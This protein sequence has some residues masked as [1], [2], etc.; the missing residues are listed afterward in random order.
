MNAK[1][2]IPT[3]SATRRDVL[4][5]TTAVLV[6]TL[7]LESLAAAA[8]PNSTSATSADGSETM[9]S[10]KTKDGAQIFYKDW[11]AGQP[12]VFHH[13]W[14]LS[15][16]DWDNQMLYFIGKGFRVIAHDR[17]GHGRSS[18]TSGGNDMDTYAA[19]VAT[20]AEAL[21]LRDAIHIGHSTGGGEVTRYVARHGKGRV[22]KAVLISAIPPVMVKS[23]TNPGGLPIEVFDG[24]RAA[25]AANRAQLYLDIASGPF[26]GFN[27]PGAVISEGTVRN[28]WRQGMMGGANAHYECIKVF[29]E[30]D[31]T[32]DLRVIDVPVLVMHGSDD[33]VVP[34]ADS[35]ELSVKLLKNGK[36]KVYDG[37]PHGMFTTHADVINADLLAFTRS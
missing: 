31:F 19:D 1:E 37:Y 28:W 24:Y 26:Y 20:L 25:L 17:R 3:P 23:A 27:R 13:G 7:P 16:D 11:G 10:I 9:S 14:P 36:L 21:D 6:T 18:Q 22:A 35:A 8:S 15:S 30:T 2:A 34:I 12:I 4:I 32:D 29:S 33:Q 5:G